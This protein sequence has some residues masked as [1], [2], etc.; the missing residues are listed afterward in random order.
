MIVK[1]RDLDATDRFLWNFISGYLMHLHLVHLYRSNQNMIAIVA[2]RPN[3][4][5][6]RQFFLRR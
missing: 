2:V 1:R 6:G 3:V 5:R 4:I